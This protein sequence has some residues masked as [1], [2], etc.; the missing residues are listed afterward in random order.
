M[1]PS[2]ELVRMAREDRTSLQRLSALVERFEEL[3]RLDDKQDALRNLPQA[4]G[5]EHHDTNQRPMRRLE[6]SISIEVSFRAA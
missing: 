5:E 4:W 2:P 1:E 6:R 3:A